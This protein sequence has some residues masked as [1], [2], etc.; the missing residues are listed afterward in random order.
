M[1]SPISAHLWYARDKEDPGKPSLLVSIWDFGISRPEG[2]H[3]VLRSISLDL[4]LRL[5]TTHSDLLEVLL[6]LWPLLLVVRAGHVAVWLAVLSG[7]DQ[8]AQAPKA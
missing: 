8:R 3:R 2:P 4:V 6:L 1:L 7:Q 5:M